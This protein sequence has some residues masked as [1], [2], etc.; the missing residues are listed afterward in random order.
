MF[1]SNIFTSS[2]IF[3][4]KYFIQNK[5]YPKKLTLLKLQA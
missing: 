2:I 3:K 5:F 4:R 1:I